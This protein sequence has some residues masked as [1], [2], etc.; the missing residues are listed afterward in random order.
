MARP[1]KIEGDVA[2]VTLSKGLTAVID[3]ADAEL[4]GQWNWRAQHKGGNTFYAV[5]EVGKRSE[6]K[7][8]HLHRLLMG[9]PEGLEVDHIDCNGLNNRRSNLRTATRGQNAR[10]VKRANKN[11][12]GYRGVYQNKAGSYCAQIRARK[13]YYHLGTFG[14]PQEAHAAYAAASKELHGEYGRVA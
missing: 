13:Q 1:V 3:A 14:T 9:F 10:N 8:I 4:V 7:T 5:R 6:R 11:K 12:S 2:Y